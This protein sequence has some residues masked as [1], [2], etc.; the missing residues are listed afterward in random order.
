VKALDERVT[1]ARFRYLVPEGRPEEKLRPTWRDFWDPSEDRTDPLS[2]RSV[3]TRR[4]QPVLRGSDRL[5]LA[6]EITLTLRQERRAGIRELVLPPLVFPVH[7]G[8]TL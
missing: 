7:V 6:V 5:P 4:G 8:R 1:E 2:G 3:I